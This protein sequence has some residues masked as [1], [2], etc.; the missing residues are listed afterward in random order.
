M[1]LTAHQVEWPS[2]MK[3]EQFTPWLQA[4]GEAWEQGDP[5]AIIK[6]FSPDAMYFET[7][8]VDP[9]VGQTAL[10][11]YWTRGAQDSQTDITFSAIPLFVSKHQGFAH[12]QASFTRKSTGRHVHLDGI[13]L[14][15]FDENLL[16]TEF[17]EWWHRKEA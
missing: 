4:Y 6:L 13:L 17:K 12:W 1:K 3:N 14:A 10:Y 9:L 5:D 11:D 2:V 7:P 15:Q 16:C 8:F